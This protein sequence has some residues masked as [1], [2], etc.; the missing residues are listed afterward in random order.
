MALQPNEAARKK[1]RVLTKQN[2]GKPLTLT[3]E[4]KIISTSEI[5]GEIVGGDIL[6]FDHYSRA[7]AEELAY[8]INKALKNP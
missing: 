1:F 3:V 6:V 2:I 7:R 5:P 8:R 4:G